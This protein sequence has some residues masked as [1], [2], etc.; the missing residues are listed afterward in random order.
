VAI[1]GFSWYY[2]AWILNHEG[3]KWA[4][5]SGSARVLSLSLSLPSACFFLAFKKQNLSLGLVPNQEETI[6]A[7]SGGIMGLKNYA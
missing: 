6:K 3:E 1:V 5:G 4:R 2:Q 7:C